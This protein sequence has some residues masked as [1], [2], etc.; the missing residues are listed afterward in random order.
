[1]RIED[2]LPDGDKVKTDVVQVLTASVA[3]VTP[4][5]KPASTMPMVVV[6]INIAAMQS[7]VIMQW[8]LGA[9]LC[10]VYELQLNA[11]RHGPVLVTLREWSK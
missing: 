7:L 3:F 11:N 1:M 5:I 9:N 8:V 6:M 2:K 10:A 4:N